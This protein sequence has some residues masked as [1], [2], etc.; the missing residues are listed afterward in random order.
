LFSPVD[1]TAP[2]DLHFARPGVSAKSRRSVVIDC[3]NR[4][5]APE[6]LPH[7]APAR[8]ALRAALQ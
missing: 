6:Q 5:Q 1:D 3:V 2:G 4:W 7:P 8:A